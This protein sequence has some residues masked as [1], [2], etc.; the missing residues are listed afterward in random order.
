MKVFFVCSLTVAL[1]FGVTASASAQEKNGVR[2]MV[3]KKT[4]DRNDVRAGYYYADRIDRTQG[5]KV[6]VQNTSLKPQPEGEVVWTILVRKYGYTSGGLEAFTGIEPL[7]ALR[8]TDKE[9][10]VMGAAQITGWRDWYDYAKDKMDYQ[11]IVKQG[12]VEVVRMQSTQGFDAVV[13]RAT[14]HKAEPAARDGAE[15]AAAEKP[16]SATLAPRAAPAPRATPVSRTTPA[17]RATPV[18]A[19]NEPL[20]PPLDGGALK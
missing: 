12:G 3:S 16:A 4:L 17:A 19:R 15:D 14:M 11:V 5:L 10:M 13:K 8:P 18:P 20:A 2:L 9:E 1:A 7:K 6:T